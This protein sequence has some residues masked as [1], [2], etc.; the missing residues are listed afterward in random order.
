MGEDTR[1]KIGVV[2]GGLMGHGIAYLFAAAGHRV[3]IYEP[4]PQVRSSM[5]R[6]LQSIVELLDDDPRLLQR[7]ESHDTLAPAMRE[8]AFV[9]EAVP[10]KLPL[11]QR[12]FAELEGAVAP[13]T[14]LASNSSAIPSR[15]RPASRS[16]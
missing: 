10:E 4:S 3:G 7:I 13:I 15:D 9:F 1:L 12:I 8:A 2:G 11:K 16:S 6:R 5:P 14:V